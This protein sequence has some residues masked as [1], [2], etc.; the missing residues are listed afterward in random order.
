MVLLVAGNLV[1]LHVPSSPPE[2]VSTRPLEQESQGLLSVGFREGKNKGS[3]KGS[4]DTGP[5]VR[6]HHFSCILLIKA[7]RRLAQVQKEGNKLHLLMKNLQSACKKAFEGVA[8]IFGKQLTHPHTPLCATIPPGMSVASQTLNLTVLN[9][10]KKRECP[11]CQLSSCLTSAP[12]QADPIRV[13][14][15]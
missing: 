7:S 4:Q 11:A 12:S 1:F 9:G 13:Y 6:H 8:L 15:P 3:F 2:P 14:I 5:N 10:R